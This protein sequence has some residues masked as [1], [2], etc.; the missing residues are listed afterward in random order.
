VLT[1]RPV[2]VGKY[3]Y[4]F[5]DYTELGI[6]LSVLLVPFSKRL[7]EFYLLIFEPIDSFSKF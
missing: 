5:L 3:L 6:E 2:S 1:D 4:S 7:F